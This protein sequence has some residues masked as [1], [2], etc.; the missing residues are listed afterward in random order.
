MVFVNRRPKAEIL[1]VLRARITRPR[2]EEL[3]T[4][5]E[6]LVAIAE[7]RWRSS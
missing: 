1:E 6:E 7:D 3:D 2:E 5:V 4:A